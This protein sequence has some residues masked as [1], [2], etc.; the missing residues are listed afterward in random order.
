MDN[1]KPIYTG[2]YKTPVFYVDTSE[3][4]PD[5]FQIKDFPSQLNVGKNIFKL[6]G[7]YKNLRENS[8]LYIEI[9][10]YENTPIYFEI[11]DR[12]DD[13]GSISVIIYIDETTPNGNCTI[14]IVGEAIYVNNTDI[15][16]IWQYQNNVMW[17]RN[18]LVNSSKTNDAEI[19]FDKKPTITIREQIGV[20]LNRVYNTTQNIIYNTGSV[21]FVNQ[22]GY[23]TLFISNG[24][25]TPEMV[26][27]TITI[28]SPINPSPSSKYITGSIPYTTTISR[29]L[30]T[31]SILL[32]SEYLID[33]S[34]SIVGH[35]YD[36]FDASSYSIN[37]VAIPSYVPTENSESYAL[38]EIDDLKPTTGDVA[39]I[40]VFANNSGTI[41]S[42]DLLSDVVLGNTEIFVTSTAS[43]EPYV[44]IGYI[45]SSSIIDTY[46]ES[47]S[48]DG[49]NTTTAPTLLYSN[50]KLNDSLYIN[51]IRDISAKNNVDIVKI[52]NQYSGK[53]TKDATYK[54]QLNAIGNRTIATGNTNP[55]I[56]FYFSGSAFNNDYSDYFNRELPITVGKRIGYLECIKN[57]SR[58]NDHI[59]TF[60]ADNT[61]T[62]ILY[63]V[64]EGGQWEIS[65]I[66]VTTNNSPGNTPN[67]TR[68]RTK[69]PTTHKS[70]VQQS[71]KVEY[72]NSKGVKSEH[73]TISEPIDWIGGNHYIDGDY[74]LITGSI[75][76]A[77]KLTTG[78]EF[79][80]R[81]NSG[82][83]RTTG[84][85]GWNDKKQGIFIWSG[86]ALTSS[87]TNYNGVGVEMYE[88]DDNYFRFTTDTNV[89]RS[90]DFRTNTFFLGNSTSSISS[91]GGDVIL[92]GSITIPS[93]MISKSLSDVLI[94]GNITSGS[95]IVLSSADKIT[96][97]YGGNQI[98]FPGDTHV[99]LTSIDL[100]TSGV[101]SMID[102]NYEDGVYLAANSN[103]VTSSGTVE[104]NNSYINHS[105]DSS[106]TASSDGTA[107]NQTKNTITINAYGTANS[108]SGSFAGITYVSD[109]SINY[110]SRS[111]VDKEYVDKTILNNPSTSTLSQV[112]TN[113]NTTNGRN[114]IISDEDSITDQYNSSSIYFL[115]ANTIRARGS[116]V[117]EFIGITYHN[118]YSGNYVSRSLVDK[119]YVD[120]SISTNISSNTSSFVT[121]SSFNNFTSS[122]TTGSFTGS[123]IG[124]GSGLTGIKTNT[125]NVLYVSPTGSDADTTRAGH[126]G[127]I[128]K[129]FLTIKAARD[130]AISG[131]LIHVFPQTFVFDNRTTNGL[132]WNNKQADINLWKN[133]VT[134]FFEP[135]TKVIFYNQTVT[136][137]DLYLISPTTTTGETC[138]VLGSLQY[139]QYS[140]GVDTTGGSCA[141]YSVGAAYGGSPV[142]ANA[143]TF[144]GQVKSLYSECC[145]Y[146]NIVRSVT[147]SAES[148]ITI[149]TD[150][151]TKKYVAGQSG[152]GSSV[153]VSGITN[154]T[155]D[156]PYLNLTLRSRSRDVIDA[157]P[158]YIAGNLYGSRINIDGDECIIK[159]QG[160]LFRRGK[161]IVNY[162]I[163]KTYY[164]TH[165]TGNLWFGSFMST[166]ALNNSII[167]I[168]GDL[169]DY[170]GNTNT[171]GV[172]NV[173][174]ASPG[175]NNNVV[176]FTGNIYTNTNS[177][178]GR[179]IAL[180]SNFA[181]GNT[182]NITGN[183]NYIGTGSTTQYMFRT[184]GSSNNTINFTGTVNGTFA[185]TIAQ[186][187]NGTININNSNIQSTTDSTSAMI[188]LNG[189]TSLGTVKVNN[190]YIRLS[191]SGSIGSGSYVKAIVNQSTIINAGT[192]TGLI[193]T[194]ASGSLNLINSTILVASQSINYPSGSI[195]VMSNATTNASWS[196]SNPVGSINLI[197]DIT[198]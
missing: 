4:S 46:Y 136:G 149:I 171:T 89:T 76:V 16:D 143:H 74:N 57:S 60:K 146:I 34:Q 144:Y 44:S 41:G 99:R 119:E 198:Y 19:T 151:E 139:E 128:M 64:I 37:Y 111:L 2:L 154:G 106:T 61:G 177:G 54:F 42:W 97:P 182:I 50:S 71:F 120:T 181:S 186:C 29:V 114:I 138:T 127:N 118:D 24:T 6:H 80:G 137:Q 188:F 93:L 67:Y 155:T 192:G 14:T 49:F 173:G 94:N 168:K 122:Y 63:Y 123:F 73:S 158:F 161:F 135:N 164:T 72:Y 45:K 81:K 152:F 7:H 195:V 18:V 48:Y 27:G 75:F 36:R 100:N 185:G 52:K 88:S 160:N 101:Y 26:G 189:N 147:G 103:V 22:Q 194:T 112:L 121:T 65:D 108:G 113:G 141:F 109:Y 104:L 145:E 197:T 15:P 68:I 87:T 184:S 125:G 90:L 47:V 180:T 25:F 21:R 102:A 92:S 183:I 28:E 130:A 169:I 1:T 176:N 78:L 153:Y 117:D 13:D 172:F 190:S 33:P 162:N 167:N 131:D 11:P 175:S 107:I 12:V 66:H 86:S 5:L 157:F 51:S 163:D 95:N 56:S 23:P 142:N 59:I 178:I 133:G 174:G 20:Q 105:V 83:I 39:R 115:N 98:S 191:N 30:S 126:V 96:D 148:K 193:N 69:V 116:S 32:K 150:T 82:M 159:N 179:F 110:V 77:D 91:T 79:A 53:F 85:T 156:D 62:G 132:F 165:Q 129:P 31:S 38:I 187:Y 134:Y 58:F 10:D 70:G 35:R 170:N 40:K 43:I 166:N 3:T 140:T 84:Y 17:Q 55:I 9:L 8:G 124:D 196:M